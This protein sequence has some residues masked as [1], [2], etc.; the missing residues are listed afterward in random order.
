[1]TTYGR[2]VSTLNDELNRLAS[3]S[4]NYPAMSSYL[5]QAGAAKAWAAAKS[6]A[7]GSVSDLVGI[8]NVI[9]GISNRST[10]LDLAGVCNKIASTTGLQAIDALRQVSGINSL[11]SPSSVDYLVV[12]GGGGGGSYGGGGGAGGFRTSAAFAISGSF[13]VTV[14]AGGPGGLDAGVRTG[15]NGVDSVFSSITSTGGGGGGKTD[16]VGF[17]GGSGGG[18]GGYSSYSGGTGNTPATSPSQGNNGGQ[19]SGNGARTAGGGGGASANGQGG[20]SGVGGPGGTGTSNSYS[21]SAVDYAIGGQGGS[22]SNPGTSGAGYGGGGAGRTQGQNGNN[23]NSGI[24]IIRYANTFAD[25]TS[26]AVGLTYT[27][28]TSGGNTI[29]QFTAGTGTVTI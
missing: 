20:Y 28:T 26:I 25:F 11:P 8:L 22:Q 7:L 15:S 12:A 21:G 1:M 27:K 18:G 5:D 9:A 16:S 19:G 24:V 4:N 29:Y 17:A 14:G 6:V 2:A 23:G 10:W 3:G 13:T